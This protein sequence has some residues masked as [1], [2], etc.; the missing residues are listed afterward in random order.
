MD[1]QE[2]RLKAGTDP[3]LAEDQDAWG[4]VTT[5]DHKWRMPS[6][7]GDYRLFYQNVWDAINGEAPLAVTASHAATVIRILETAKAGS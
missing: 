3:W 4:I 5:A 6:E 2:E 1:P 7:L